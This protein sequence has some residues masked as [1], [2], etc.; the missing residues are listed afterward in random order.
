M[1]PTGMC[2]CHGHTGSEGPTGAASTVP[3]PTGAASTVPGPTGAAST[4]PGPTGSNGDNRFLFATYTALPAGHFIGLGVDSNDY[5]RCTELVT[6]DCVATH[7]AFSIRESSGN[8]PYTATLNVNGI[9][10]TLTATILD[11]TTPPFASEAS[12]SVPLSKFDLVCV[13]TSWSGGALSRGA[14]ATVSTS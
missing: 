5:L 1:G 8:G 3:G 14:C 13:S 7:L 12:G 10:S 4:V 11:G 6:E 9:D 2:G